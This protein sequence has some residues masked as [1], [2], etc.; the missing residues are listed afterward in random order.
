MVDCELCSECYRDSSIGILH[1][2][3]KDDAWWLH[4]TIQIGDLYGNASKGMDDNF[5]IQIITF[6]FQL[7]NSWWYFPN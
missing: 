5:P 1:F 6:I 7:V 3:G 4:Q 2:L